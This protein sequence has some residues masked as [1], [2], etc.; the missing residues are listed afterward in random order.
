MSVMPIKATSCV[1][2]GACGRDSDARVFSRS[3]FGSQL[4][5]GKLHLLS[6]STLPGS[7][8]LSQ[9]YSLNINKQWMKET[10]RKRETQIK[11]Y[12]S[13]LLYRSSPHDFTFLFPAVVWKQILAIN[14]LTTKCLIVK[15][16]N[17]WTLNLNVTEPLWNF[18]SSISS[19]NF[20]F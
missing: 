17:D 3:H 12:I 7:E 5:R 10:D 18:Q 20:I 8:V 6:P 14:L 11:R 9:W 15:F 16:N 1:D 4:I 13:K 2:M 19:C